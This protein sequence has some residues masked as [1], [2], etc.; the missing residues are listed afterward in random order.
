MQSAT[1]GA[2]IRQ[3]AVHVPSLEDNGPGRSATPLDGYLFRPAGERKH[4]AV[5]FLHGCGGLCNRAP[6]VFGLRRMTALPSTPPQRRSTWG[7]A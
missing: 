1:P 5:V 3:E 2:A 4:P 7:A 6:S